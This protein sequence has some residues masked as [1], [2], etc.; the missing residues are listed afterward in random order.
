MASYAD[1]LRTEV[2]TLDA[3]R[4]SLLEELDTLAPVED[5]EARTPE[6]VEA[7]ADE[8]TARATE[9]LAERDAKVARIAELDAIKAER[10]A[11]PK[12]PNFVRGPDIGA[13]IDTRSAS[14]GEVR[15]AAMRA[16]EH[17]DKTYLRSIGDSRATALEA[18]I[19][20][21]VSDDYDS[22]KVARYLVATSK[23]AYERAFMKGIAGRDAEWTDEERAAVTEAR[24]ANIG[25]DADGG[26]GVPIIIDPTVLITSGQSRNPLISAVRVEPITN[27]TWRGVSSAH[28]VWSMD[29]EAAQASDDMVTLAQPTIQT[30]KPQAFI[31]YSFEVGMD[32]P[33]FAAQMGRV[34]AQG[35]T[36]LVANQLAIGTGTTPETT[37]LFVGATT[38]L[39]VA[40]DNT[41]VAADV[42][43][44][45]AAVPEDFR[46]N[47]SWVMNVDVE[48]EIRA[49]GS[50]TATSRF[51]VDQTA[52]GI[53]LLNGKPVILT[54]HAPAWTAADGQNILVFGD[55]DNMIMAQRL[56][57]SL[58]NIPFL[59]GANQR[60]TGQSGLY[61]YARFGSGVPVVNAF[62]RLKNIT[63]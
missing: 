39:D 8:I 60:P 33:G 47:G 59:F 10:A 43:S 40:T 42:D 3:E 50:G 22:T 2:E 23:A 30:E 24:A 4:S 5:D 27:D 38:T 20:R 11:V 61:G 57:M 17:A 16:I 49:F 51:T 9:I 53:T 31:P 7:R 28:A 36:Y 25:T 63:T 21:G 35:Y 32:Y 26:Y 29:A 37:G 58:S 56:G 18:A 45:Y 44:T 1:I 15:D 13:D 62:R 54:D 55:L 41:F 6:L 34:L 14:D 19:S 48:N 46:A 52:D 12:P